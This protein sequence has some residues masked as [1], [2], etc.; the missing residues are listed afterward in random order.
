[1]KRVYRIKCDVAENE[2]CPHIKGTYVLDRL[3]PNNMCSA[4]FTA[5]WPFAN[6]MRHSETTGFEDLNGCVVISCPDGWVRFRLSRISDENPLQQT[7][8][9]EHRCKSLF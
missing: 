4:A 8:E 9:I 3:T 1:M 6:A 5:I 7:P 2:F